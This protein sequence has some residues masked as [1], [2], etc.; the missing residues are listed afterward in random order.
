[1]RRYEVFCDFTPGINPDLTGIIRDDI[2]IR[3]LYLFCS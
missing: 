2:I 3:I 1:M